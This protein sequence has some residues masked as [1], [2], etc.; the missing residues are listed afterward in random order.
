MLIA[1][2]LCKWHSKTEK[3]TLTEKKNY[4]EE[5]ERES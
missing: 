3:K 2:E 4:T 1:R 5:I